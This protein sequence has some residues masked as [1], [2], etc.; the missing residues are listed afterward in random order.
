MIAIFFTLAFWLYSPFLCYAPLGYD[1]QSFGEFLRQQEPDKEP[2]PIAMIMEAT[3]YTWTGQR[4]A[5]GT[6]PSRG[7][8]AVDENVIPLGTKLYIEGY[9]E[10]IA[11][12]TGGAIKG[13]IIDIYMETEDECWEWGRRTVEVRVME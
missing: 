6:W 13:H 5:T 3:A 10:A 8:V 1:M 11:E 7:T 9:G 4:T 12:D 2:E